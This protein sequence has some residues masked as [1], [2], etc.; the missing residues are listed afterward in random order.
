MVQPRIFARVNRDE[1]F[2]RDAE[3]RQIVEQAS[4]L[5]EARV[6]AVLAVPD[7]G[8]SELLRQSY[9]HK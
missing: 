6:L 1:F 3:L 5:T 4:P 7:A 9:D 2:G 8:A